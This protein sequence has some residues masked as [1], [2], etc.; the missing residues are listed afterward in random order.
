VESDNPLV[1]RQ[2]D[3]AGSLDFRPSVLHQCLCGS[4]MWRIVASFEDYEIACYA[5]DMECIEC[6]SLAIAPTPLD[7]PEVDL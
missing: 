3:G 7:D 5:L 2:I 4:N 1:L 6:G